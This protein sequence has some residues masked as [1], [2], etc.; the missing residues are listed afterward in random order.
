[1]TDLAQRSAS[2]AV[3]AHELARASATV[4]EHALIDVDVDFDLERTRDGRVH[5]G[6]MI[7]S[8]RVGSLPKEASDRFIPIL[9]VMEVRGLQPRAPATLMYAP[10]YELPYLLVVE[11]PLLADH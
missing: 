10:R 1:L 2:V 5:V 11:V 9:E 6:V 7:D 3:T 4:N 8:A